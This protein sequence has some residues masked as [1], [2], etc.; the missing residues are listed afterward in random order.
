MLD[1]LGVVVNFFA[2][3]G[4]WVD[5]FGEYN[6]FYFPLIAPNGYEL[7]KF[8][9]GGAIHT[10]SYANIKIVR[11]CCSNSSKQV[12]HYIEPCCDRVDVGSEIR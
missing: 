6:N 1:F 7:N 4:F 10:H 11:V 12:I 5:L 9:R 8:P 3:V 2:V